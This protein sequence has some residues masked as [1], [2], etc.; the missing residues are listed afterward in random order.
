LRRIEQTARQ[1]SKAL[2]G[3]EP[4]VFL[5]LIGRVLKQTEGASPSE[6]DAPSTPDPASRLIIPG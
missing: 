3:D 5:K 2:P 6:A 1:A 4:P